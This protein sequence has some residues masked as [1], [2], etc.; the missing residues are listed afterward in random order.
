MIILLLAAMTP[1]RADKVEIS[2]EGDERIVHLIGN[3][4][5]EGGETVITCT[6]ATINEAYGWVKLFG[7]VRLVDENGEVNAR[8]SIYYFKEARGYMSES[9]TVIT[10]DERIGSDSL[11][12][13]GARDSVEMYGNV[14]I[15]DVRNNMV[16]WGERG[17]YNLAADEGS[18][19]GNPELRIMREDKAPI[20]IHARAF[21]LL[22]KE[23]QFYGFDSVQVVIDSINVRCDTF[24]YNLKVE[25]GEM[26]RPVIREK[27]NELMGTHGDFTMKNK[28]IELLDVING[29][30]VYYTKEGSKNTVEGEKITVTFSDGKARSIRVEGLPRG[31]LSLKRSEK[32]AGD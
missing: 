18:L 16:V 1:F 27:N 22:T 30:S 9:V 20:V 23:N 12:Y 14:V 32:S 2:K 19:F 11:Y 5:I 7:A 21:K 8:S 29:K 25:A 28:E 17:W 24:S 6:E 4:V 31:I 26:I 3:V 15:E 10:A 13:D